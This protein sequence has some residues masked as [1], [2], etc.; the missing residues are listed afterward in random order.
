MFVAG[1]VKLIDAVDGRHP[2]VL[3]PLVG[4]PVSAQS[5]LRSGASVSTN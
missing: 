3:K 2:A 4:R 5:E 1:G